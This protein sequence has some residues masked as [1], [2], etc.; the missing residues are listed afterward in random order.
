MIKFRNISEIE[1]LYPYVKA[2]AG[3]D[4]YNGD[5]GT[6]TEGTFALAANAKQVVMNIEVGDD[7]G[8]DRYFIAKGSDLRVLDLDKLDGK[9]LEIY[10]KQIPTAAPYVEVT[11]IIGNHKGI[12]VG[13]VASA[14][15][16]QSVS[17]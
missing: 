11:E 12:V 3:T 17:K 2:V 5:F 8:L 13:V 9:E 1:K 16:T 4:V 7:E 10:G 14:P 6:V 15:A